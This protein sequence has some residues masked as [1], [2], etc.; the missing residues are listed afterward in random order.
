MKLREGKRLCG[1]GDEKQGFLTKLVYN[2][3]VG[4]VG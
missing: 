4:G 3:E 1:I 2:G